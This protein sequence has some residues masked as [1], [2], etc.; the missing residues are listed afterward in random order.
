MTLVVYR[1]PDRCRLPIGRQM[2]KETSMTSTVVEIGPRLIAFMLP[3]T[4]ES[5]RI[6]QFHVR[7]TL[8]FQGLGR[9]AEDAE[10]I[11]SGSWSPTRY[12]TSATMA[13]K[14]SG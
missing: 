14:R 10:I 4:P 12:S 13:R 6:A 9:Y 8:D 11:T 5:V 3:S 7:A 2:R 1:P